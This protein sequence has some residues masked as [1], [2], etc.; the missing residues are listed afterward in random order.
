MPNHKELEDIA[1]AII[2]SASEGEEIEVVLGRSTSTEVVVYKGEIESLTQSTEEGVTV[3][4][5]R[6]GRVGYATLGSLDQ[7]LVKSCVKS[8][9][10]NCGYASFDPYAILAKPDGYPY[11][12]LDLTD[13]EVSQTPVSEK[14]ALALELEKLTLESD[15]RIV[16]VP[17]SSYSDYVGE[18]LVAS[19]AGILR[20]SER[21]YAIASAMTVARSGEDTHTGYGYSASRK[22]RDLSLEE[23]AQDAIYR[24]VRLLGAK[25][26]K[27]RSLT[28]VFE[29]RVAATFLAIATAGLSADAIQR[30]RSIFL[31]RDG[32]QVASSLVTVIDDP[33]DSRFQSASSTDAE[34]LAS[35]QNVLIEDGV[36]KG[37]LYDSYSANRVGRSSTANA[38]RSGSGAP[39]PSARAVSLTPGTKD[40]PSIIEGLEDGVV[41]Q[42]ISGVH[43]GVNQVSGDFSVGAEGVLIRN[44]SLAEAVKGVTISS[45]LQ[46][47]LLGIVEVGSDTKFYPSIAAGNTVVISEMSLSGE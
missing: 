24:A 28:V 25:P 37:Y 3:R 7:K 43:S 21:S 47:M 1:K 14:I 34:G 41:I 13:P 10:E 42:S 15:S 40:A 31:G 20:H 5:L 35:R 33:T 44:G 22:L 9:R 30:N 32:E 19:T 36:L 4:V 12:E 39:A 16:E 27:S 45:T 29:P 18:S 38:T 46:K 6:D 11:V 8:A 26:V 17:S 23:A 2:A